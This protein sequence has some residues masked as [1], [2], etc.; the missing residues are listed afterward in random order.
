[1]NAV[2]LATLLSCSV[3]AAGCTTIGNDFDMAAAHSL[4]PGRSTVS[5]A[6]RELGSPT[7]RS[8]APNNGTLLQWQFIMGT[9]VGGQ[10]KHLALLF[11]REGRFVKITHE[12]QQ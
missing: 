12:A 4:T 2:V 3:T 10:G 9:V 8:A 11:D 5:D 6:I 7:A 1:L